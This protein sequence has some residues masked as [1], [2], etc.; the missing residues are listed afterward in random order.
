MTVPTLNHEDMELEF[1]MPGANLS[2]PSMRC[3]RVGRSIGIKIRLI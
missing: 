1:Q 2:A 3:Q